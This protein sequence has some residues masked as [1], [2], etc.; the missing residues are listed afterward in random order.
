MGTYG[1]NAD[2]FIDGPMIHEGEEP[3]R[4]S[5]EDYLNEFE[6]DVSADTIA[7]S[8]NIL[9]KKNGWTDKLGVIDLA[10]PC[11]PNCEEPMKLVKG[12]PLHCKS[13]GWKES[14]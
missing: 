7:K 2:E 13:C 12:L 3:F 9:C 6:G 4:L 1:I 10:K 14:E 8:W 5:F 11:C